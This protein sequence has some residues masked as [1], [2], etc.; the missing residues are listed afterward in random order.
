M[1]EASSLILNDAALEL[2]VT[3]ELKDPWA[4]ML[5]LSFVGSTCF[6]RNVIWFYMISI[7][8]FTIIK[9]FLYLVD[10]DF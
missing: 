6:F 7:Y 9:Y 1:L 3:L 10:V 5:G 4:L 2:K 8:Y